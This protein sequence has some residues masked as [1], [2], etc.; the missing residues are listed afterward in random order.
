MEEEV[1]AEFPTG[2]RRYF[3]SDPAV[4][5]VLRIGT[6]PKKRAPV[7]EVDTWD[8]ATTQD[9]GTA[10]TKRA[11]TLIQAEHIDVI[12]RISGATFDALDLRRNVLVQ[13]INLASLRWARFS[14]GTAVLE[15]T[16]PCEPCERMEGLLGA[17]GYAAMFGMGGL[18]A[19]IVTPGVIRVGDEVRRLGFRDDVPEE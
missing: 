11:V 6:R 1:M 7:V 3:E 18:C 2:L 8:L 12:R 17:G 10:R 14:V 9:H 5:R 13:G 19:R 15:G 16:L 4:G